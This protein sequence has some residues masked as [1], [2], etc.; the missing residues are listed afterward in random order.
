MKIKFSFLKLLVISAIVAF[1]ISLPV[2]AQVPSSRLYQFG[3]PVV[4]AP[5]S[6]PL[7]FERTPQG[8]MIDL[9]ELCGVKPQQD[10]DPAYVGACIPPKSV[11][12]VNCPE[13]KEQGIQNV[14][15]VGYDSQG[16]DGD[17]DNLGCDNP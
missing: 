4:Q 10:C 16:L 11:R 2:I 13:L 1:T 15:I 7:C 9:S 17:N 6:N 14:R 8:Q 12:E 3:Y 5:S